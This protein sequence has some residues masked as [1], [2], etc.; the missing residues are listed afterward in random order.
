MWLT[1]GAGERVDEEAVR[2]PL[3]PVAGKERG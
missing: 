2:V 3:W 1:G